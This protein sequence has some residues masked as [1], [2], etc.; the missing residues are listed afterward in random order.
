M[1]GLEI[2]VPVAVLIVRAGARRCALR[3]SEVLETMRPLPVERAG[4]APDFVAGVAVIRGRPVPV[5]DL[6]KLLGE[7]RANGI[8]RFVCLRVGERR[9]ALAVEEVLDLRSLPDSGLEAMP[10]L[11]AGGSRAAALGA[12]DA[13]LLLLLEGARILP[14]AFGE[15]P[16]GRAA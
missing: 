6:A 4:D 16:E 5:V 2:P 12:L 10:P 7:A 9:V 13:K 14:E 1:P 3:A 15:R 8:A 11:L